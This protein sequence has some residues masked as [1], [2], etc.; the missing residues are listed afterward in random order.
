MS[1]PTLLLETST[2][3]CTLH[4]THIVLDEIEIDIETYVTIARER[5]WLFFIHAS[6]IE[7]FPHTYT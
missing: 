3:I 6:N 7:H 4:A 1:P 5:K 2:S